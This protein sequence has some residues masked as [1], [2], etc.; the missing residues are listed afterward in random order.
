[1]KKILLC[2]SLIICSFVYSERSIEEKIELIIESEMSP[3]VMDSAL[4]FS[5]QGMAFA[6]IEVSDLDKLSIIIQPY[7]DTY[8]EGLKDELKGL[9]MET[10]T[11]EEISA[12]YNFINSTAGKSY[13]KKQPQLASQMMEI[14]FSLIKEMIM[15]MSEDIVSNPEL[16]EGLE[17]IDQMIEDKTNPLLED[18]LIELEN[19][20]SCFYCDLSFHSFAGK[21]LNGA[22]LSGANLQGAD[23]SNSSLLGAIFIDAQLTDASFKGADLTDASFID[24]NLDSADFTDAVIDGVIFEEAYLCNTVFTYGSEQGDC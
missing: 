3:E 19:N 16:F 2:T 24:A 15:K 9:Y 8:S 23:F 18:N 17:G 6:G 14:S 20:N 1:M 21:T 7:M 5:K 11:E 10:Y 13:R 12:Y 4:D 22:N